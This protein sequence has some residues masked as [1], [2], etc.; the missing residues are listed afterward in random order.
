MN[1]Q[2]RELFWQTLCSLKDNGEQDVQKL[3]QMI[4]LP[5]YLFRYSPVSMNSLE[6][7]RSNKLYFS[8]ANYYDDPFDTFLHIDIERIRDEYL[9]AFQTP[10]S[11]DA[12]A[13]IAAAKKHGFS[14]EMN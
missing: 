12:S 8:S 10:E 1:S 5:K 14:R 6:A 3:L 11:M 2:E 4:K 7:L 9:S 13:P